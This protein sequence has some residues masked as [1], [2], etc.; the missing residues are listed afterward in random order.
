M[1]TSN[2]RDVPRARHGA[3]GQASSGV[4]YSTR[5]GRTQLY[6]DIAQAIAQRATCARRRVGCVL[7]DFRGR[8]LSTGYNGVPSGWKHCIDHPCKGAG[9][10]S[11][12]G[13]DQCEAIHAEQNALLNCPDVNAIH[14]AYVTDSP[15]VHCVK[16][17]LNTSCQFI[18]FVREYPHAEAK[19]L[20]ERDGSRRWIQATGR[21][22]EDPGS[23]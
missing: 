22:T 2:R 19:E 12:K 5:L 6:L 7:T 3:S 10:P 21:E 8:I 14:T 13:L 15:C 11:G 4:V 23:Q 20:W 16:L 1:D 9:L 17:L 18:Y